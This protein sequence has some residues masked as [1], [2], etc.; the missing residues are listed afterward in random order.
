MQGCVCAGKSAEMGLVHFFSSHRG[1]FHKKEN[2]CSCARKMGPLLLL[3][4]TIPVFPERL[5]QATQVVTDNVDLL[6][7][8][9]FSV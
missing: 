1:T 8:N 3:L 2:V 6:M 5:F 4:R 7:K 9:V